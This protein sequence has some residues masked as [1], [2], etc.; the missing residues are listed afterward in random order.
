[1]ASLATRHPR[2]VLLGH[3]LPPSHDHREKRQERNLIMER[4]LFRE[5]WKN[6]K[7]SS[8]SSP[9]NV[10]NYKWFRTN[11]RRIQ[12]SMRQEHFHSIG[13][14]LDG[15]TLTSVSYSTSSILFLTVWTTNW[16]VNYLL[17]RTIRPIRDLTP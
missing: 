11:P 17:L 14:E 7:I 4:R 9:T 10:S 15:L 16:L 2:F 1:M 3:L 6:L 13:M 12:V 8:R 5:S